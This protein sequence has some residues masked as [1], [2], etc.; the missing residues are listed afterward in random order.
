M[1]SLLLC[2]LLTGPIALIAI[3]DP[4]DDLI[5][6]MKEMRAKKYTDKITPPPLQEVEAQP[7]PP[8]NKAK[9]ELS[10]SDLFENFD[11]YKEKKDLSGIAINKEALLQQAMMEIKK[12]DTIT[13]KQF[14]N[15]VH[16]GTLTVICFAIG[17]APWIPHEFFEQLHT[18]I[19]QG[20]I[21]LASC[22]AFGT[23]ILVG[24]NLRE[25]QEKC[26]ELKKHEEI[27]K[28]LDDLK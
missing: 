28:W 16:Y 7:L 17:L 11:E 24:K 18:Q 21:I 14:E 3:Q 23:G 20:T 26:A 13:Q 8:Y 1:K 25:Y 6:L 4:E 5:E 9:K 2:A 12:F 19:K 10:Y 15:I 27:K 22:G